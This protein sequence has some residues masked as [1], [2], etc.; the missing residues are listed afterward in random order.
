[1]SSLIDNDK[2]KIPYLRDL[3]QFHAKMVEEGYKENFKAT[4][5]GLMSLETSKEYKPEELLIV[6][7]Y[8]FEGISDPEDNS[9]LYVIEAADGAKGTMTDAYGAYS[10]PLVEKI[11]KQVKIQEQE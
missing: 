3:S 1:M 2:I 7:F 10:D 9:I 6:N 4:E 8:R 11:I 5:T